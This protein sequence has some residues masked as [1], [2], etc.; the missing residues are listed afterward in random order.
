MIPTNARGNEQATFFTKSWSIVY[1]L[2]LKNDNGVKMIIYT[3]N[4]R[5]LLK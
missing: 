5:A 3:N 4:E 2:N 1:P